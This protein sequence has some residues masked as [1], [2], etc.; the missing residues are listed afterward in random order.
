MD[1]YR[2]AAEEFFGPNCRSNNCAQAVADI[3]GK[4]E[5]KAELSACGGGRAE[6]GYCGALHTALRLAPAT[7]HET[8]KSDFAAHSGALT[9]RE[10]KT[11]AKTPCTECVAAAAMLADRHKEEIK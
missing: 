10:I 5:I 7:K 6:Q 1:R 8:I 4:P 2:K 11:V 9:C 3:C